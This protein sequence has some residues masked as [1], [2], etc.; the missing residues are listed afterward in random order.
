MATD[1]RT[2]EELNRTNQEAGSSS[3]ALRAYAYLFWFDLYL[4]APA[5]PLAEGL[6]P[7]DPALRFE[8]IRC[9]QECEAHW[10]RQAQA[11]GLDLRGF[12]EACLHIRG[13]LYGHDDLLL[14]I[15]GLAQAADGYASRRN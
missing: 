7:R 13:C 2:G 14:R 15:R 12:R 5:F 4:R 3:D 11:V 8:F 6:F 9:Q 1:M 10:R